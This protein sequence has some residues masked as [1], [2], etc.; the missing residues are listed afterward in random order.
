MAFLLCKM[1]HC[2][3][4]GM[5]QSKKS[6][7]TFWPGF[8]SARKKRRRKPEISFCQGIEVSVCRMDAKNLLLLD[9]RLDL[10][11]SSFLSKRID[12]KCYT[13]SMLRTS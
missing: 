12:R 13:Q 6:P 9:A 5:K 8:C 3:L 11:F 7:Q 10:F 2:Y 1:V 4:L